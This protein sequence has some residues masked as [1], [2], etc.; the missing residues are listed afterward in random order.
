MNYET[1]KQVERKPQGE[2]KYRAYVRDNPVEAAASIA[3]AV[4]AGRELTEVLSRLRDDVV[5]KLERDAPS[6][7]R[8]HSDIELRE[9]DY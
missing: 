1:A 2:G 9:S 4:L 3:E 5:V 8:V 7:L 6:R